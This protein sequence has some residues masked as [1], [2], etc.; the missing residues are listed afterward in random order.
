MKAV[1]DTV[2]EKKSCITMSNL[3]KVSLPDEMIPYVDRFDFI[4]GVQATAPHNCGVYPTVTPFILT[5]SETPASPSSSIAS[6]N[7]SKSSALAQR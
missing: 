6:T 5:L 2:G 3:G 7:H 1:F 4:L